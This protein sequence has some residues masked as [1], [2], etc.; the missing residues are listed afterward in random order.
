MSRIQFE[1]EVEADRLDQS[2]AEDPQL[3]RRR[4]RNLRRLL[5]VLALLLLAAGLGA[6]ALHLRLVQV[7]NEIARQLRESLRAEVASLRIGDRNA[8]LNMQ[9]GDDDWLQAQAALFAEYEELKSAGA[10]D[11]RGDILSMSV[12]GKRAR[13]L[14]REDHF[15]LPYARLWFYELGDTGW[16]HVA[17]D[18]AFWGESQVYELDQLTVQYREADALFARQLGDELAGW[19]AQ[20]CGVYGCENTSALTV[21]VR[22]DLD[23]LATWVDK[24]AGSLAIRSPYVELARADTPF[25]A[26]H[27]EALFALLGEVL[28][29]A[30]Q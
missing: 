10:I 11:L 12:E 27:A 6:L 2:D 22:P 24:S 23:E 1:W 7:E 5:L 26:A 13:A 21:E 8:W 17:P 3:R 19:I 20:G 29:P 30:R 15:G 14:L 28:Q 9:S 25:V 4:R 18:F 16:R